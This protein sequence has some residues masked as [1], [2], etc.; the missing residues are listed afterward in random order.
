[1]T[2]LVTDED[3]DGNSAVPQRKDVSTCAP[4]LAQGASQVSPPVPAEAPTFTWRIGKWKGT[5]IQEIEDG[6]L[7]W[8]RDNGK[9]QD[10]VDAARME[11]DRRMAQEAFEME[12]E[13]EA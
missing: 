9:M 10:H 5:A 7:E 3:D 2:G 4:V 1:M 6:Y 12:E 13:T 8:F 11:L